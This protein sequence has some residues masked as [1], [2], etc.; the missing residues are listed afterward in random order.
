MR[1]LFAN[2]TLAARGGT[3][4]YILDVA[5]ALRARGHEVAAF[6]LEPG[7]VAEELR[8]AGI[9]VVDDPRLLP[10]RPDVIHGHH[11]IETTL[12]AMTAR[13]SP[14]L[15]FCHGPEAWQ[16]APCRLPNVARWVAVDEACRQR[17]IHEEGI[18]AERVSTVLNFVDL[19]RFAARPPLP[20]R[21]QRALVFS[22]YLSPSHPVMRAITE[23]CAERGITVEGC[24][25]GFGNPTQ[26]PEKLLPSYDIV[27]AKARCALEGMAAGCAVIQADHFGVG[28]LVTRA[29]FDE[30]RPWNFGYRSMRRE[31]SAAI[32][33][34]EL[35]GYDADDAAA[36][37][38]RIRSEGSL[39]AALSQL[40][41]L[42]SEAA[43]F[44]PADYDP[45]IAAADFLRFHLFLSKQPLEGL[46]RT[47]GLPLRL[48]QP[49]ANGTARQL[50]EALRQGH[51]GREEKRVAKL[52]EKL[53]ATH[54]KL[55]A[56]Q[57][58][59]ETTGGQKTGQGGALWNWFRKR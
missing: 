40:E 15:S 29:N 43:S 51:E 49:G 53:A 54:A 8:A 36:V 37:T 46:R 12:V 39:D 21:P 58:K 42:Y 2:N 33:G 45:A 26:E 6:T 55:Q 23:A 4:C 20:A 19:R 32:L 41:A 59:R 22:N 34:A 48:P 3:E 35:E 28:R 57:S 24:G 14:V 10:W 9:P 17:L 56:L 5:P 13:T 50:W 47:E 31:A 38:A 18:P 25:S 44:V 1:I 27:F 52:E 30:L 16:E 7:G 11:A